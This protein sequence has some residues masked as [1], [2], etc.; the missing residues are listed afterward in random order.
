MHFPIVLCLRVYSL[1]IFS[2][3]ASQIF[4]TCFF[5]IFIYLFFCAQFIRGKKIMAESRFTCQEDFDRLVVMTEED[6]HEITKVVIADRTIVE[7]PSSIQ[8]L[9]NLDILTLSHCVSLKNI[10]DWIGSFSFLRRINIHACY[11]LREL[12][13]TI[14]NLKHLVGFELINSLLLTLPECLFRC[15]PL[16]EIFLKEDYP[17]MKHAFLAGNFPY[18]D[19]LEEIRSLC[20]HSLPDSWGNCM[21]LRELTLE[22]CLFLESIPST[23]GNLFA[24]D[25]EIGRYVGRDLFAELDEYPLYYDH[26]HNRGE[27]LLNIPEFLQHIESFTSYWS[28]SDHFMNSYNYCRSGG[29]TVDQLPRI[30]AVYDFIHHCQDDFVRRR[31]T[32]EFKHYY[33]SIKRILL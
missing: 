24:L 30:R 32:S 1:F 3:I 20:I 15:P 18:C 12:P 6:L 9:K 29:P 4:L 27:P 2:E 19:S 14:G 23:Y 8:L 13:I 33:P 10:P 26:D 7:F 11:S 31:L 5:L 16:M 22:G 17:K 25:L 21:Y 28:E